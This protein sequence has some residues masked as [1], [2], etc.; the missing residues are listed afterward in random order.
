MDDFY[1]PAACAWLVLCGAAALYASRKGRS[2]AGVFL[3]SLL[4]SPLVGFAVAFA[5]KEEDEEEP[6]VC[7]DPVLLRSADPLRSDAR[8]KKCPDCAEIIKLEAVVCRFCGHR[9]KPGEVKDAAE[10][11]EKEAKRNKRAYEHKLEDY[12]SVGTCPGCMTHNSWRAGNN[13]SW[14]CKKCGREYPARLFG[15][16]KPGY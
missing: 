3:L 6:V 4:L 11:A 14:E 13:S 16:F 12:L 8:S 10:E 2:G 15:F 5:M 9:F 1:I 7:A